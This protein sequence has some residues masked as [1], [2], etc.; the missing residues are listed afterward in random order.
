M[1]WSAFKV[2]HDPISVGQYQGLTKYALVMIQHI[3][4]YWEPSVY[5]HASSL[6]ES[7]VCNFMCLHESKSW[8]LLHWMA[9]RVAAC[10]CVYQVQSWYL[11]MLPS[12]KSWAC[13]HICWRVS[14]ALRVSECICMYQMLSVY[15]HAV[16]L[17]VPALSVYLHAWKAWHFPACVSTY[18]ELGVY[19]HVLARI[20]SWACLHM[21]CVFWLVLTGGCVSSCAGLYQRLGVYFHVSARIR[22]LNVR[23]HLFAH[24]G[25]LICVCIHLWC[26]ESWAWP[27]ICWPYVHVDMLAR[28][29][30]QAC[31]YTWTLDSKTS[32][33]SALHMLRADGAAFCHR[34]KYVPDQSTAADRR[35]NPAEWHLNVCWITVLGCS[36][37]LNSRCNQLQTCIL[38]TLFKTRILIESWILALN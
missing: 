9:L 29:K 12:I 17:H 14:G 36:K 13:I 35:Q 4:L 8:L 20:K 18:Q 1:C 21:I 24:M 28:V 10:I 26:I 7:R 6:F 22:R 3:D 34:G 16:Y 27:C 31:N 37:T 2:A 32:Y 30:S 11:H 38:C 23:Q 19:Y 25:S 5:L 15:L 33:G